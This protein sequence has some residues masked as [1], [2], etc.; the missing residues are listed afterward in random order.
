MTSADTARKFWS[1]AYFYR[2]APDRDR[3]NAVKVLL[4]ISIATTGPV[5]RRAATLMKEIEDGTDNHPPRAG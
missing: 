5:Q 4:A 2:R 3:T 1:A